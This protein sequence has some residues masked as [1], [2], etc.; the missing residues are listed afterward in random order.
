MAQNVCH[1]IQLYFLHTFN[2]FHSIFF[3][4]RWGSQLSFELRNFSSPPSPNPKNG[5]ITKN[6]EQEGGGVSKE[7][8]GSVLMP[9]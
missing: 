3:L 5:S 8:G 4:F 2:S 1:G 6:D 7:I 9:V